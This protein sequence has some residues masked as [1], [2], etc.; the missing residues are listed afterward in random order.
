MK[1][2]YHIYFSS[3][4]QHAG[5]FFYPLLRVRTGEVT[6]DQYNFYD[7]ETDTYVQEDFTYDVSG[8][9]AGFSIGLKWMFKNKL[10][11]NISG[12]IARNLGNVNTEYID[13]LELR[14]GVILG[15]RF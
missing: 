9:S 8:V 14:F 7:F 10:A 15:Y 1:A 4:K 11:L 3:K 5:F 12:D 2:A 13:N 6:V